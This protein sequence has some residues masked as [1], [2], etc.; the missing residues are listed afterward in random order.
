MKKQNL[1]KKLQKSVQSKPILLSALGFSII[2]LLGLLQLQ[3]GIFSS[4]PTPSPTPT[5]VPKPTTQAV[6]NSSTP[7]P[8]CAPQTF[9]SSDLGISFNYLYPNCTQKFFT[10]EIGNSIYLY[11]RG[12]EPFSGTDADFLKTF[13]PNSHYYYAEVFNKDPN[14][15]LKDAIRQQI[16]KGYPE[17]ICV[18]KDSRHAYPR[19]DSSYSA[20][21]IDVSYTVSA[22]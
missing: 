15:S 10:R 16:L 18:L 3:Y 5:F 14:L 17:D 11:T 21:E 12:D 13:L 19:E 7:D 9:T 20:A 22:T 1:T 8:G 6:Y 2:L 4:K